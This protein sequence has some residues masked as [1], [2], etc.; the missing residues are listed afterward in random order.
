M[1]ASFVSWYHRDARIL[2]MIFQDYIPY[3]LYPNNWVF[4]SSVV[5]L[6][7]FFVLA[8]LHRFLTSRG[9]ALAKKTPT[10]LDDALMQGVCE[11]RLRFYFA[12]ALLSTAGYV[13]PFPGK[14]VVQVVLWFWLFLEGMRALNAG[15]NAWIELYVRTREKRKD[16]EHSRAMFRIIKSLIVVVIITIAVVLFMA[17][18]GI[19]VSSLIASLGIGGIAVA[20][21]LQNVLGDLFSSFSIFLDKPFQVGDAVQIGDKYGTVQKIGLKSTRIKMLRGEELVVS[22][23]ELTATQIQNFGKLKKRRDALH[24]G[25]LYETPQKKLELIPDLVEGIVK[26]IEG[27]TFDR[28]HLHRLDDSALTYEL[29]YFVGSQD[30]RD[31]MD[32]RQAILLDMIA[33]FGK[34]GIEFAYPTRT[35]KL[36]NIGK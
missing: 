16:R 18:V 22:N 23:K 8:L 13:P 1:G 12:I 36:E 10:G 34:K 6:S 33:V 14:G 31:Y 17:N 25:V 15:A 11:L 19:D 35:I 28:C 4:A 30:L 21:A 29:V 27:V 32:A 5:F 7:V 3:F 26:K 9:K 24:F 20:L 2:S